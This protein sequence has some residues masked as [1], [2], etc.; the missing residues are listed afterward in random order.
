MVLGREPSI[1]S[2]RAMTIS[3]SFAVAYRVR[4][5]RNADRGS[6]GSFPIP[7][8]GGEGP[9]DSV[10]TLELDEAAINPFPSAGDPRGMSH[11]PELLDR[12]LGLVG[13]DQEDGVRQPRQDQ[14]R[15][16]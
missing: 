15:Q 14:P 16:G 4:A 3:P 6:A 9:I 13:F 8:P 5:E 12:G 10:L 1:T 7:A 11:P 2:P